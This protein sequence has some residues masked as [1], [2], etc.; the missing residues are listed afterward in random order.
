MMMT[1]MLVL[2]VLATVIWIGG[3]FFAHLVLR[4]ASLKTLE[5]KF[6][7]PLWSMV[8]QRFFLWVWISIIT[9]L[10]SGGLLLVQ[11]GGM[12]AAPMYIHIMMGVGLFMVFLYCVLYFI[13][14]PRFKETVEKAE[15]PLA[16]NTL[17]NMRVLVLSNLILGLFTVIVAVSGPMLSGL[18]SS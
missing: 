5:P 13:F 14:Y 11:I 17:N 3:M 2:H 12:K 15:Y 8:F 18:L 10:I 6:R 1:S 9:L 7:L 4:P 16:A